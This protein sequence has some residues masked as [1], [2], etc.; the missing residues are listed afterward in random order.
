MRASRNLSFTQLH[1]ALDNIFNLGSWWPGT[2]K[3]EIFI[4]S[5]LTQN[6]NWKNVEKAISN[7][8]EKNLLSLNLILNCNLQ[9]LETAIKPSGFYHQKALRLK[10]AAFYIMNN[11]GFLDKFFEK[12]ILAL[13]KELLSLN[14]I[15]NETADS[16]LLYCGD[17]PI[18]VIDAYTKRVVKRFFGYDTELTYEELQFL[19]Q[20][21]M[22][23]NTKEYKKFHGEFVELAKEHCKKQPICANCPI[24]KTCAYYLKNENK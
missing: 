21:E 15:G 3:D 2:T 14:G 17:K 6:T 9:E 22:T 19:I 12:D 11:Y 23:P 4:S 20:K 5:I 16:I 7:L 24:R 8:K 1:N 18:F 10:N 13:R